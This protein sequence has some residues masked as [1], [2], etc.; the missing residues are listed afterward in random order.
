MGAL[1][2]QGRPQSTKREGM[3]REG[4]PE[5]TVLKEKEE[6]GWGEQS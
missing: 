3:A 1:I 2:I 4:I 6:M 5:E